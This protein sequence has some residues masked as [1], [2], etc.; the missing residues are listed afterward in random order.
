M[1]S[2]MKTALARCALPV[3][4][5]LLAAASPAAEVD[6]AAIKVT[7][8][9]WELKAKGGW[10]DMPPE[11]AL[12][13]DLA[14]AWMAEGDGEW[15]QFDLGSTV[16]LVGVKVAISTGHEREYTFDLLVAEGAEGPWT[17]VATKAKSGGKSLQPE[18]FGFKPA[19]ARYVRLVGHGNT[20]E[21]FSKW[22]NVAEAAFV[23]E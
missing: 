3:V 15:I 9:S 22:C 16:S 19:K 5:A 20:S 23:T 4:L 8:S 7:A 10:G 12:D 17:A 21:K 1:F 11:R 13:G 2:P 6:R 14:T 18:L